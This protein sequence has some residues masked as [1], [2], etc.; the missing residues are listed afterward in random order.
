LSVVLSLSRALFRSFPV[1]VVRIL[2]FSIF[3]PYYLFPCWFRK[4]MVEIKERKKR[5]RS[6]RRQR[7]RG[8]RR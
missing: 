8:R 7:G 2:T 5:E 6:S 3:V 1:L 4:R